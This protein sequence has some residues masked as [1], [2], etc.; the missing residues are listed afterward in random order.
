[1]TIGL[2]AQLAGLGTVVGDVTNNGLV[3]PGFQRTAGTLSI[4]GTYTQSATGRL[5]LR[6]RQTAPGGVT[7]DDALAVTGAASLGGRVQVLAPP[8]SVVAGAT[9]PL[10]TYAAVVG[11]FAT[12]NLPNIPGLTWTQ[13]RGVMAFNISAAQ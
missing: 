9:F 3:S 1:L 12:T 11:N 2:N 4:T 5:V 8:G 7:V 10:L 13:M 6:L